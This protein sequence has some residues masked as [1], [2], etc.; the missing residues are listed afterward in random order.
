MSALYTAAGDLIART[1]K[2]SG[3]KVVYR[4][5]EEAVELRCMVGRSDWVSETAEG[6]QQ[7]L[8]SVDFLFAAE[9]LVLSSGRVVPTAGDRV[10]RKVRQ[11]I[12]VY[13]VMPPADGEQC[14]RYADPEQAIVRVHTKLIETL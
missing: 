14:Y 12:E 7:T 10:W 13:E 2:A 3:A 6:L 5:G 9:Q 11:A 1:I 4:R 8:Q